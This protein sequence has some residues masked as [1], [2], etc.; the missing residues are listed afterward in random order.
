MSYTLTPEPLEEI[1]IQD[2]GD[3]DKPLEIAPA[4]VPFS[5]T[6]RNNAAC[7]GIISGADGPTAIVFGGSERKGKLC[8][9]CSALHFEPIP[10][11]VEWRVRFIVKQ[12]EEAS[13]SLI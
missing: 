10:G 5:P 9:A 1:T 8:A 4:N 7:I 3:G 2:C 11:D 6:E 13:F 12:F